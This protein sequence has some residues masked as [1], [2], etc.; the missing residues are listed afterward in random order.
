MLITNVNSK[1]NDVFK[2]NNF[3]KTE[4]NWTIQQVYSNENDKQKQDLPF[5]RI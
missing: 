3:T 2:V 4:V 5:V 1:S